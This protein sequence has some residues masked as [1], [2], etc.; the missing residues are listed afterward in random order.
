MIYHSNNYLGCSKSSKGRRRRKSEILLRGHK[1]LLLCGMSAP[2]CSAKQKLT[3]GSWQPRGV[4]FKALVVPT[5]QMGTSLFEVMGSKHWSPGR[6]LW[7]IQW[8]I[9]TQSVQDQV[10]HSSHTDGGLF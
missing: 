4:K 6:D 3:G 10:F 5:Q 9:L 8:T 7:S 2:L 1:F